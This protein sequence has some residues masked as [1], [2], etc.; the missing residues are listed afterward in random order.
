MILQQVNRSDA[1]QVFGAFVNHDGITITA[2]YPVFFIAA[3]KNSASVNGS[4]AAQAANACLTGVGSFAGLARSDVAKTVGT[5]GLYQCYGYHASALVYAIASSVTVI[6]GDPMG[7]GLSSASVGVHSTGGK[8]GYMGP[9]IALDTVTA[10]LSSLT[11]A[12]KYADHVFIR[13]M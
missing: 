3:N 11:T 13:A 2:H 8:S 10:T 7:P 5:V 4:D 9:V 6:P 12:P 1:E